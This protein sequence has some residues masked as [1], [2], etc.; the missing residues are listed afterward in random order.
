MSPI[1]SAENQAA[2]LPCRCALFRKYLALGMESKRDERKKE[3]LELKHAAD[4]LGKAE[5][6]VYAMVFDGRAA[7]IKVGG[8]WLIHLPTTGELLR[9]DALW[10]ECIDCHREREN[11]PKFSQRSKESGLRRGQAA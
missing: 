2:A 6:T 3:F 1:P 11:L 8:R 4:V 9:R 5:K 10:K 7:G